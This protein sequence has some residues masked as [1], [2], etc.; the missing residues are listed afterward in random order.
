MTNTIL[1]YIPFLLFLFL[2]AGSVIAEI[3]WLSRKGWGTTGRS[4]AFV[5][6]TDLATLCLAGLIDSVVLFGIFMMVMGPAGRGSTAPEF[7]Y[8]IA[9]VIAFIIP[10]IV[11]IFFKRL[12]LYVFKIGLGKPAWLY[13]IISSLLI[14]VVVMIPPPLVFYIFTLIWR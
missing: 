7:A 4:T 8:W 6:V 11:L 5:L 2:F 9:T 1:S 10:P 14:L 12:F 13:S 3:A